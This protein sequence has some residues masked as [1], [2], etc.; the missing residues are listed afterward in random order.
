MKQMETIVV[1][2]ISELTQ[3][4][5]EQSQMD[6]P[7]LHLGLDSLA[8]TE[9]SARLCVHTGITLS[10]TL[11]FEQPTPRGI[12]THLQGLKPGS[13]F[14]F[15]QQTTVCR[16]MIEGAVGRWPDG[17]NSFSERWAQQTACL[18]VHLLAEQWVRL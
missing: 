5:V 7:N 16:V 18:L 11:V 13:E 15:N 6:V 17:G 14:T 4:K 9:L 10:S 3:Q 2:I 12:A 8:A 1:G